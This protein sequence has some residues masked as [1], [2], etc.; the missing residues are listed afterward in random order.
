MAL[1]H[2]FTIAIIAIIAPLRHCTIAPL[3]HCTI[4]PLPS[5]PPPSGAIQ[6]G[7]ASTTVSGGDLRG[8]HRDRWPPSPAVGYT[9]TLTLSLTHSNYLYLIVRFS[10]IVVIVVSSLK[11]DIGP[12][13]C[14]QRT[15][16]LGRHL[17]VYPR[18]TTS[19]AALQQCRDWL[20]QCVRISCRDERDIGVFWER[21]VWPYLWHMHMLR[22]YVEGRDWNNIITSITLT[23]NVVYL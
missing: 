17:Q 11:R 7:L 21:V 2:H 22:R 20:C 4:A 9:C 5:L 15:P 23:I 16:E 3:N 1:L 14:I 13:V 18:A 10:P 6:N 12:N 8:I 19:P